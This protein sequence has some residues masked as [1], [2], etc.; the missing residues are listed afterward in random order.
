[1]NSKAAL[2]AIV[3]GHVQGVYFRA[4]TEK[5]AV[6]L[7]LKGYVRNLPSGDVEVLAEGEREK[8]EELVK[9]LKIG[10]PH[11]KVT[12]VTTEWL[13]TTEKHNGFRIRYF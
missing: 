8:L 2:H 6:S 5:E 4:F 7:G 11:S 10:P 13:E 9:Q 1:M 3:K 12:Q